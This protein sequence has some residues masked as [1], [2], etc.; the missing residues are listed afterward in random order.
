[1]TIDEQLLILAIFTKVAKRKEVTTGN[2]EENIIT[3]SS[4]ADIVEEFIKEENEISDSIDIEDVV[5]SIEEQEDDVEEI[6]IVDTISFNE[7][8]IRNEGV[9]TYSLNERKAKLKEH[10]KQQEEKEEAEAI[11]DA[12][13]SRQ[14]D[15][16][17]ELKFNDIELTSDTGIEELDKEIN[18]QL[19]EAANRKYGR[20]FQLYEYARIVPKK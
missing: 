11:M 15:D 9:R 12:I 1:M 3:E 10:I 16:S 6:H 4:N 8:S 14:L 13:G 18:K 19:K 20:E 5:S 7:K 2:E 17:I